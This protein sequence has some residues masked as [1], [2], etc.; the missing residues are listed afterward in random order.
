M[1]NCAAVPVLDAD[2]TSARARSAKRQPP[3]CSFCSNVASAPLRKL[4]QEQQDEWALIGGV[5]C[6]RHCWVEARLQ[7]AR[8]QKEQSR[9]CSSRVSLCI[10]SGGDASAAN[11]PDGSSS[12]LCNTSP[13]TPKSA[14]AGPHTPEQS[15]EAIGADTG[16]ADIGAA[17]SARRRRMLGGH[18]TSFDDAAL[19][20][21]PSGDNGKKWRAAL[22]QAHQWRQQRE[23]WNRE[24]LQEPA[25]L[26][27][28]CHP[29]APRR[30][31]RAQL[32]ALPRE[33]VRYAA[34]VLTHPYGGERP[35]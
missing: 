6:H 35:D 28:Q 13:S 15:E 31:L 17:E 18:V 20:S 33:V 11:L 3:Q 24:H 25:Q 34:F 1:G 23:E 5:H 32:A 8:L 12:S 10:S 27:E 21:N 29:C 19:R 30:P 9:V 16:A 4:S 14:A 7:Q 26:Q 22:E 2:H